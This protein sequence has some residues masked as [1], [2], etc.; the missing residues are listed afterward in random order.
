MK[1]TKERGELPNEK[2]DELKE[3]K[4]MHEEHF[5]SN[6]LRKMREAMKKERQSWEE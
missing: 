3:Y 1:I 5:W 6:W 2:G 4:A